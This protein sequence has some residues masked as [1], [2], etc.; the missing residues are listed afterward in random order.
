M[1]EQPRPPADVFVRFCECLNR[2]EVRY[3]VV[4]SEAVAFHGAPRFSAD[5]DTFVLATRAN[6]FRVIAAL[7]DF[8]LADLAQTIDPEVWARTGATFRFGEPPLQVD[9]L[10]QL[11]GVEFRRVEA[12]A[13]D[14][15]YGEVPV[16]FIGL[17]DLLANKR[18]VGRPKDLADVE[19]L[20]QRAGPTD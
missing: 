19:A 5:F 17:D 7:E 2:F 18:A 8:G 3:L 16:R 4:G 1:A 13:V 14:G 15:H 6:L 20:Q 9:V 11:T 10:L 12:G